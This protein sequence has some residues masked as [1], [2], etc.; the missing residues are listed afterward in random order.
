MGANLSAVKIIATRRIDIHCHAMSPS[1]RLAISALGPIIRTPEWSV[2]LAIEFL[3][4]HGTQAAV[5]SLSTPGTHLGND[6]KARDLARRVNEEFASFIARFPQRL[7]AFMTLPLPDVKGALQEAEF[8]TDVLKL[9]GVGLLSSYQ[10][11]YLGHPQ[12]D[13]LL[14]FLNDRASVVLIHPNNHPST[15]VIREN[16]NPGIGNFLVEFLFDTTRAALNLI[17]YDV[18]ERF[19]RIRFVLCHAG[20]TVPFVAW[21]VA[22]IASRQMTVPPWNVQY[23]SRF[24]ERHGSSLT[25]ET[26]LEQFR[27]FW[28][29]TA[30]SAGRQSLTSLKEVADP[31]R[32]LF[33]SDWP[34]CPEVMTEDML[35]SRYQSGLFTAQDQ[36]RID[37]D[38]A[39]NLFPRFA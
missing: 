32:I 38:N 14:E 15:E 1:Y 31:S 10:G 23:R 30:L 39:L 27:R 11:K 36:E 25:V 18:L 5:L 4:R 34:Y 28:F 8:A 13:P 2:E 20:G 33:G 21:R 35:S 12:F 9:D 26:V 3:D 22:E 24:M 7:G 37:R 16:I 6:E 29:D 19:P 17:F